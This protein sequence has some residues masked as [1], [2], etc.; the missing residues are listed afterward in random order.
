MNILQATKKY[1]QWLAKHITIVRADLAHKH[2]LMATSSFAFMRGTFYR[3]A[4]LFAELLPELLSAPEVLGVG[5]LHVENY[6]SWRD[7]EGRLVWGVNDFDEACYLPFTND[8]VRLATSAALAQERG[9]ISIPLKQTCQIIVDAYRE[10]LERQ[11]KAFVLAEKNR[12]LGAMARQRLKD[13]RQFFKRLD[14]E[15]KVTGKVPR[16]ALA[17]LVASLPGLATKPALFQRQA[18]VGSL[19]RQRFL[20]LSELAGSRIAREAKA[21]LPSAWYFAMGKVE[22]KSE[23]AI[24]IKDLEQV[25]VRSHDPFLSVQNGW[26]VRRLAPDCARIEL[27]E[28]PGHKDERELLAAMGAE[29]ANV[30]LGT[31]KS[32]LAILRYLDKQKPNWLFAAAKVMA[33]ATEQDFRDWRASR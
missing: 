24:H 11:G 23:S 30:H 15:A 22:D 14:R 8:L 25:C 3:W 19:G 26:V 2:E 28:L 29:V 6:G 17:L 5:D 21:I 10:T 12:T 31:A 1:E 4:M 32:R 13:P 20:A 7:A 18:G 9:D 16:D 27:A 33:A